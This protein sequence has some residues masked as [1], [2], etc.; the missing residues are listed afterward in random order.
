MKSTLKRHRHT[1]YVFAAATITLFTSA[2]AMAADPAEEIATTRQHAE[3][4]AA[5]DNL[6][7]VHTH[8]HHVIN[9][10]EG[11]EGED[12][13]A[14]QLNPCQNLG[15][16]VLNDFAGDDNQRAVLEKALHSALIGL[17]TDEEAAAKKAAGDTVEYLEKVK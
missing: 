14:D 8:L 6:A 16:G 1:G 7:G 4:A 2:S 15:N 3:F 10:L 9:C 12:F 5:A 17:G 11:P 13:D